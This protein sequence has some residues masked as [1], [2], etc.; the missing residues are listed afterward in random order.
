MGLQTTFHAPNGADFLGWRLDR[1]GHTEI[2]YE[3]D[4]QRRILRLS[5]AM[6]DESLV[7]AMQLAVGSRH[8][9]PRLID[10]L[11]KRAILV[12]GAAFQ[13]I[14]LRVLKRWYKANC[15]LI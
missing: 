14:K 9:L 6:P 5:E 15:V 1:T 4:R 13:K 8:V 2:V 7:E 12:E 11:K 10:E 3:N